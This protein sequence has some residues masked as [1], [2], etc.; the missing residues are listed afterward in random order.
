MAIERRIESCTSGESKLLS[1]EGWKSKRRE[2]K[3][4][5]IPFR[6]SHGERQ[7]LLYSQRGPENGANGAKASEWNE[8]TELNIISISTAITTV[9]MCNGCPSSPAFYPAT[10]IHQTLQLVSL[11]HNTLRHTHKANERNNLLDLTCNE[12]STGMWA[13]SRAKGSPWFFKISF[14]FLPEDSNLHS[15]TSNWEAKR[16]QTAISTA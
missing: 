7:N 4:G 2:K 16:K 15:V 9:T 10:I 5:R 3:G 14:S 13:M 8:S 6:N 12:W 11:C 1:G